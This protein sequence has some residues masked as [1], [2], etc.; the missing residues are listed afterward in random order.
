MFLRE[1]QLP[2]NNRKKQP[3]PSPC[4]ALPPRVQAAL[5]CRHQ[6]DW[7]WCTSSIRGWAESQETQQHA[8]LVSFFLESSMATV[9][10]HRLT[11]LVLDLPGIVSSLRPA[12]RQCRPAFTCTAGVDEVGNPCR[13]SRDIRRAA[14]DLGLEQTSCHWG[15]DGATALGE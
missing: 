10:V 9:F 1:P 2:K 4:P 11:R 3:T 6:L 13:C 5:S 7:P 12:G 8:H 14:S 15:E